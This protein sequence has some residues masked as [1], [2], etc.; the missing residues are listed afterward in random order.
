MLVAVAYWL[1]EMHIAEKVDM[2]ARN[3]CPAG[4]CDHVTRDAKR[5]EHGTPEEFELAVLQNVAC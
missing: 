1:E 3:Y 4:D 5:R 2:T